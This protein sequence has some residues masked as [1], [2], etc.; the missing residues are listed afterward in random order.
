MSSKHYEE[1]GY[2]LDLNLLTISYYLRVSC[3]K[4]SGILEK[5]TI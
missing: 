1:S 3:F 4:R 2:G 5:V